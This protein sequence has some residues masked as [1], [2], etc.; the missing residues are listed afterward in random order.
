MTCVIPWPVTRSAS[1]G[2]SEQAA[3]WWGEMG[4][5]LAADGVA[6][7]A[8]GVRGGVK[9]AVAAGDRADPA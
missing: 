2:L 7:H 4:R 6:L 1:G 5:G 8:A 3:G 9:D